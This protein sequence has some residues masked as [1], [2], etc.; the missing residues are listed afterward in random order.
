MGEEGGGVK[1][2]TTLFL[3][4]ILIHDISYF[5]GHLQIYKKS[6][7][8][9]QNSV[10]KPKIARTQNLREIWQNILFWEVFDT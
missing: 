3:Y 9:L 4:R 5:F 1:G 7:Q 6:E 8:L 10:I 2:P